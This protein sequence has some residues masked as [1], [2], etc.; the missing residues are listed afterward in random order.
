MSPDLFNYY[1]EL[2]LRELEKERGLEIG[3]QNITNL[4]YADDSFTSR[5]S[6]GP[7]EAI[8]CS[9]CRERKGLSINCK[10]TESMVI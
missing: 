8:G 4:R 10:K 3:G 1:S 5:I 7:S 6:R 9:G 2:M